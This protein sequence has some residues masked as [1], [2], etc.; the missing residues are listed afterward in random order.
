MFKAG[1]AGI[2]RQTATA[3]FR[4]NAVQRTLIRIPSFRK[5]FNRRIYWHWSWT[6]PI[7]V[8]YGIDTSG[9]VQ[10]EE[11]C[12][13]MPSVRSNARLVDQIVGY[14]GSQPSI[15]RQALDALPDL[16]EYCF[17]DLGCGK[18]RALVVA[19]EYPFADI[20]G[21]EISP[22]LAQIA[23][24]NAVAV[25]ANYP[26]R[27]KI[28]VIC[29]DATA[30]RPPLRKAV[31]YTYHAFGTELMQEVRAALEMACQTE[32]DHCF[33]VYYNPVSSDVF[34]KAEFLQRWFV[35]EFSYDAREFGFGPDEKDTVAIWQSKRGE[36]R[37]K[38][39][40]RCRQI[41][42]VDKMKASLL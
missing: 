30:F 29:G 10:E 12:A 11:L 23:R 31:V 37:P 7:D 15:V 5:A 22:S 32:V 33:F 36:L 1:L 24:S 40:D 42:L 6:H 17:V 21:I 3:F 20:V 41:V 14:I 4:V 39:S 34:D 9:Y 16:H 38:Q 28:S 27:T 35:K 13:S 19:S 26:L 25:A 18:G 2:M 8:E